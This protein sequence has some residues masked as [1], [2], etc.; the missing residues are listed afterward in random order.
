MDNH[1]NACLVENA[2]PYL[3]TVVNKRLNTFTQ[4]VTVHRSG[5]TFIAKEQ[6]Q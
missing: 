5:I 3:T 1:I 4:D 2:S 6:F